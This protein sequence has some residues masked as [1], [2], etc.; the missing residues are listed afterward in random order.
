MPH[1]SMSAQIMSRFMMF[2][3]QSPMLRVFCIWHEQCRLFVPISVESGLSMIVYWIFLK[4]SKA[5]KY[6][7]SRSADLGDTRILIGSKSTWDT[8]ILTKSLVDTRFFVHKKISLMLL[9]IEMFPWKKS[10]FGSSF[11][12]PF[13]PSFWS[14]FWSPFYLG[15]ILL[16]QTNF[17]CRQIKMFQY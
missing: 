7:A 3:K 13:G 16:Q 8:R 9:Y 6:T 2:Y 10:P 14:S 5:S 1:Y 12:F 15:Q 4:F 11:E 17:C